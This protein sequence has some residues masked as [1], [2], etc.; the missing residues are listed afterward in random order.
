MDHPEGVVVARAEQRHQLL[1]GSEAK[2]WRGRVGP[3]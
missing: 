2:Q 1:I 3:N